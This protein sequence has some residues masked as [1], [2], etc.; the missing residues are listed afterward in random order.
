[1]FEKYNIH[2]N[3]NSK[4]EDDLTIMKDY[5]EESLDVFITF[6]SLS[7]FL[8]YLNGE[9]SFEEE[10]YF[11]KCDATLKEELLKKTIYYTVNDIY[12][13]DLTNSEDLN[14]VLN[15]RYLS[16]AK[17]Y[18]FL[19][20]ENLRSNLYF[21]DNYNTSLI[22]LED[23]KNTYQTFV[24]IKNNIAQFNFSPAEIVYYVYDLVRNQVYQEEND[25]ED[26]S[27][28]RDLNKVLNGDKIVCVGFAKKMVS[29]C[30]FLQIN[31]EVQNWDSITEDVGHATVNV[32]IDDPKYKI[33]GIYT[34]DPTADS[35]KNETDQ[36][37][38]N[39]CRTA[40]LPFGACR[41]IIEEKNDYKLSRG[42][43]L[44]SIYR[45]TQINK[46]YTSGF[47]F[48]Q[49]IEEI[50]KYLNII[51]SYLNIKPFIF[52][53]NYDQL[54][55]ETEKYLGFMTFISQQTLMMIFT[56]VR[57]AEKRLNPNDYP[58]QKSDVLKLY[59]STIS[60]KYEKQILKKQEQLTN[61]IKTLKKTL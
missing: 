20:N 41:F 12:D 59:N 42:S 17:K 55:K 38:L 40:F 52:N 21:L 9:M 56:Q 22:T 23:L 28:S 51:K 46:N 58:F 19:Q 14:L 13:V 43:Y 3:I 44:Y 27:V 53:D 5:D 57:L 33:K 1:M 2:I 26:P 32:Y 45:R 39:S 8:K 35:K 54:I 24:D 36:T 47:L 16:D 49:N 60:S 30:N 29:I 34:F 18:Q 31:A 25:N 50:I 6:K 10:N 61:I 11:S 48:D 37:Y 7:N 4:D 15:L